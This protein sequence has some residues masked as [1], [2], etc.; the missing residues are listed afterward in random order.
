MVVECEDEEYLDLFNPESLEYFHQMRY[1]ML[2]KSLAV[3]PEY[4]YH[5][6]AVADT[7]VFD[8]IRK[9]R[10]GAMSIPWTQKV[11]LFSQHSICR[12]NYFLCC[13]S[14]IFNLLWCLVIKST[15][16]PFSVVE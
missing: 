16:A 14:L 13:Q 1:I 9:L 10:S 12:E 3:D 2:N 11:E 7:Q 5:N 4:K 8:T 6:A 15:M